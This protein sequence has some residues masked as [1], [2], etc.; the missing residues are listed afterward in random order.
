MLSISYATSCLV[1]Q[2]YDVS[3]PLTEGKKI[4]NPYSLRTGKLHYPTHVCGPLFEEELEFW[5]LDA[6]QVEPCCWMTYTVHRDTE[7]RMNK[8]KFIFAVS[9]TGSLLR[10]YRS[11]LL[12]FRFVDQ[13]ARAARSAKEDRSKRFT[14]SYVIWGRLP[15]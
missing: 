6:N 5:G 3:A 12:H 10:F 9:R 8:V 14:P 15:C 11:E 1:T 2:Y 13:T 7:V 4:L